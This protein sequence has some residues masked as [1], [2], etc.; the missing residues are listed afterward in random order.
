MSDIVK[1]NNY[2]VKDKIARE[3]LETKLDKPTADGTSGQVLTKTASGL[4][5]ATP[6]GGTGVDGYSPTATVTQTSTGATI[7]ITDKNGTTT[8]N[9]TNGTDGSNTLIDT[10]MSDTSVNAVANKVIKS[11]VDSKVLNLTMSNVTANE[12]FDIVDDNGTVISPDIDDNNNNDDG[13]VTYVKDGLELMLDAINNTKLGHSSAATRQWEDV[14]GNDYA[15]YLPSN[16]TTYVVKDTYI[17]GNPRGQIEV[18]ENSVATLLSKLKDSWSVEI[19]WQPKADTLGN[20][21]SLFGVG[22]GIACY[23]LLASG[24]MV[25]VPHN[26]VYG[27]G[28]SGIESIRHYTLTY[29]GKTMTLYHD[30]KINVSVDNIVDLSTFS[31]CYFFGNAAYAETIAGYFCGVRVYSKSLSQDEITANYNTDI[32]R[33]GTA[34]S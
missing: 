24:Q 3:L 30:A 1:I 10:A 29:D 11:Y 2:S 17:I 23:P 27:T 20:K 9:V 18:S 19:I 22:N 28:T 26:T 14:S 25:N 5:W 7:S 32:V 12:Y 21:T 8:A 33:Y 6:T 16:L 13:G 4:E 15:T 31:R 34:I